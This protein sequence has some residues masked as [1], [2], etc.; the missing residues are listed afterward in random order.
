M[1]I[2]QEQQRRQLKNKRL[3]SLQNDPFAVLQRWLHERSNL[4]LPRLHF[5]PPLT[6]SSLADTGSA[7]SAVI[8]PELLYPYHPIVIISPVHP[9]LKNYGQSHAGGYSTKSTLPTIAILR[10]MCA[11]Y[12]HSSAVR[13]SNTIFGK[14][15]RLLLYAHLCLSRKMRPEVQRW[16]D[17]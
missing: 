4:A 6:A 5:M 7:F 2:I 15:M 11:T 8:I 14:E 16:S 13:P 9:W 3:S 17:G 12:S 1:T 10:T